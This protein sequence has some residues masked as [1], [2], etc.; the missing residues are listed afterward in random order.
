VN[1]TPQPRR[2][3][4]DRGA[5]AY[6]GV[7]RSYVRSLVARGVLRRVELPATDGNGNPARVLRLDVKDLDALVDR[8][9]R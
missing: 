6:L 7:C 4:D 5:A 8:M 2:L 1:A 9:K 3:L